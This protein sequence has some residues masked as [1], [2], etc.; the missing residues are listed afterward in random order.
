MLVEALLCS[1]EAICNK[2]DAAEDL[3][4]FQIDYC[5]INQTEPVVSGYFLN[6]VEWLLDI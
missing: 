4:Q 2:L 1:S 3:M 6:Q 5:K